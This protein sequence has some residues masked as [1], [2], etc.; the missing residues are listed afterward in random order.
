M[1][2]RFGEAT[3]VT[4]SRKMFIEKSGGVY[5]NCVPM[6]SEHTGEIV[7]VDETTGGREASARSHSPLADSLITQ[8]PNTP[9]L[10]TTADC[11][12]LTLYAADTHTIALVHMSRHT[13]VRD[14]L[15]HTLARLIDDFASAPANMTAHLGPHIHAV[16]YSFPAPLPHIDP[17]L[18]PYID[19]NNDRSHIDLAKAV[20]TI[21]AN[22]GVTTIEVSPIDTYQNTDYFSHRRSSETNTPE[23]RLATLAVLLP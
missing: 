11:I 16:S 5:K 23:G 10:L 3:V 13:F 19:E 7:V 9:L 8:L 21:L 14:L 22:T 18:A 6:R 12:P 1:G 17:K 2:F 15:E 20:T 4:N